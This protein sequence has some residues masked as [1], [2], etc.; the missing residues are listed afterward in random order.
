MGSSPIDTAG[1]RLYSIPDSLTHQYRLM[2]P[3]AQQVVLV[4]VHLVAGG[5]TEV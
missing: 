2:A 1:A 3:E 5:G 4:R